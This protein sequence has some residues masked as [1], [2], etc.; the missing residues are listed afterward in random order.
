[1]SFLSKCNNPYTI[2]TTITILWD[3]QC[4]LVENDDT[5]ELL[6]DQ[7]TLSNTEF[8]PFFTVYQLRDSVSHKA[9]REDISQ[10]YIIHPLLYY[11]SLYHSYVCWYVLVLKY[12]YV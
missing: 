1:M 8:R 12:M 11:W 4:W 9:I 3:G 2:V 5:Y 10:V 6:L 7:K